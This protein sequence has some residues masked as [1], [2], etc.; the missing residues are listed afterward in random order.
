MKER[1]YKVDFKYM[2]EYSRGNWSRQCCEVYAKDEV[3]AVR[4]CIKIYGL[5]NDNV[6]FEIISVEEI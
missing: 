4:E 2:D 3:D 5:E 6:E 1:Q